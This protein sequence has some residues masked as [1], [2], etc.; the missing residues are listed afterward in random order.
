MAADPCAHLLRPLRACRRETW[1]L[2]WHCEAEASGWTQCQLSDYVTR[3]RILERKERKAAA[4]A[5]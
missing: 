3:M 5:L 4:A 1:Y 2:P